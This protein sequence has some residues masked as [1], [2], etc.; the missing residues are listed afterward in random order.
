MSFVAFRIHENGRAGFQNMEV[1]QLT[2]GQVVIK[3]SYS[4]INYKDALAATGKGRI[5]KVPAVNGGIDL[6]GEVI[7]SDSDRFKTGDRVLACGYGLSETLDGGYSEYARL[8]PDHLVLIPKSLSDKDAMGIGTAGFTAAL[9]LIAMETNGQTVDHGPILITGA[10][11]GVGS[12]SVTLFSM[13]GYQVT[14]MTGKTKALSYLRELG[15]SNYLDRASLCMGKKPLEKALWGGAV[16]NV[17][18]EILS[19]ITRTVVPR[20]NIAS[21]GLASSAVL[22]TTVMPFILR[23]ISLLGINCNVSFKVRDQIWQRLGSDLKPAGLDLIANRIIAF[24]DLPDAFDAYLSGAV[25][26]RTIVQIGD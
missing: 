4:G 23:G 2:A 7:S 14:A 8:D 26:G 21:I 22:D 20:G 1:D 10:S 3:V 12:F 13:L 17:G 18:G 9:A 19:W 5:L 24:A 11:G 25:M 6:A 15:S 16:D